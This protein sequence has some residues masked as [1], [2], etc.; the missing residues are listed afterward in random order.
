MSLLSKCLPL[1]SPSPKSLGQRLS[2]RAEKNSDQEERREVLGQVT[3]RESLA[4]PGGLG[5]AVQSREKGKRGHT[6][7]EYISKWPQKLLSK[8]SGSAQAGG[9][10]SLKP[11]SHL[12]SVTNKIRDAW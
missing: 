11:D 8:V 7:S 1:K 10:Q 4:R 9:W 12:R 2:K 6:P 3:A 5:C